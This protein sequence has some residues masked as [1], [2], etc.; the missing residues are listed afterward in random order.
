MNAPAPGPAPVRVAGRLRD[1][2][3][4][5]SVVGGR[6]GR[7]PASS[8]ADR[9]ELH[10]RLLFAFAKMATGNDRLD[11]YPLSPARGSVVCSRHG[12]AGL[13]F[14]L[15]LCSITPSAHLT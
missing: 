12:T 1:Y 13:P 10:A 7:Q 4:G 11:G 6:S 14:R 2:A 9:A 3:V 15:A 8:I 5:S